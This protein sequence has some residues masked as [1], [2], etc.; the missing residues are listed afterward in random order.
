MIGILDYGVGNVGAIHRSLEVQEIA[1]RRVS[2]PEQV[3]E[4]TH[5]ILP[6]VGHFGRAQERFNSS[7]LREAIEIAVC[8]D[9]IPILGICVGFQMMALASDESPL[10]GLGWLKDK[11]RHLFA[12]VED[13]SLP[14]PHMGW[15]TVV[16]PQESLLFSGIE[17]PSF[18][19]LHS[20]AF[21]RDVDRGIS[22]RSTYGVDF[23]V[24]VERDNIFG[25]QFH[26]EKSHVSGLRLLANF[27]RIPH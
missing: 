6:G 2:I 8:Q 26:P 15:N 17:E 11:V 27:A 19:F 5:L 4:V 22:S 3:E 24:A 1:A 10:P 21:P 14:M 25:V 12:D 18:Y 16:S 7:G 23:T 20:F 13:N 9:R